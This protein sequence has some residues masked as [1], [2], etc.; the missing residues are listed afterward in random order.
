M[1]CW[2]FVV[3]GEDFSGDFSGDDKTLLT[4]HM[5]QL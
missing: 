2:E 3:V 4:S 1:A 5:V